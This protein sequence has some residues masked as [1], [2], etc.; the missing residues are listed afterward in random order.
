MKRLF[1]LFIVISSLPCFSQE[2]E[3]MVLTYNSDAPD[4]YTAETID[5][6]TRNSVDTLCW[7]QYEYELCVGDVIQKI[8][9]RGYNPNNEMTRHIKIQIQQTYTPYPAVTIFDSDCIIPHGGTDVAPIDLVSIELAEPYVQTQYLA[10]ALIIESS[11]NAGESP[12]YF[13]AYSGK[14]YP[15]L[16]ISTEKKELSGIITNQ[17]GQPIA[18]AQL[19]LYSS[20]Y[21]NTTFQGETD[22]DGR[23]AVKVRSQIGLQAKITAPGC[24]PY[25]E[26]AFAGPYSK[27]APVV[28]TDAVH[29]KAGGR[30]SIVL[31]VKPDPSLG[32]YYKLVGRDDETYSWRVMVFE[33]EHDPKANTPYVIFPERDF[34]IILA[35]Y[36]LETLPDTVYMP[37]PYEATAQEAEYQGLGIY[38]AYSN[39]Q[40]FFSDGHIVGDSP[41]FLAELGND[42]YRPE[43]YY[44]ICTPPFRC[45]LIEK[46]LIDDRSLRF[47]G[48]ETSVE[49]SKIKSSVKQSL[50]YDLQGR[51]LN[52]EPEKGIYIQNGKKYVK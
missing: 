25:E 35:D 8:V 47:I 33:R 16:T 52:G 21:K 37:T 12:I 7:E 24:A 26:I 40:I 1:Y 15:I 42:N 13:E 18:G 23:Y 28:L 17:D 10:T 34:D 32:R 39:K 30:S 19:L 31:P 3:T 50:L 41:Y 4:G 20:D 48:E 36:D 27:P 38:G 2:R 51:Q 49:D 43:S 46:H 45:F 11:G 44:P 29:Y 6:T 22:S 9:F 14:A 5:A